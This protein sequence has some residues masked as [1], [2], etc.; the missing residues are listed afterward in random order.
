M[1]CL[2]SS[3]RQVVLSG[4]MTFHF[5]AA[6]LSQLVRVFCTLVSSLDHGH[7]IEV[8]RPPTSISIPV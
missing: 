1:R 4:V 8:L 3:W 5:L 6:Y 7:K 2:Q